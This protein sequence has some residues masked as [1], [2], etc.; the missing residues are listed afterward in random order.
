MKL[1][2]DSGDIEEI[3]SAYTWGG[4]DGVTSNPK[5][6]AKNCPGG[7]KEFLHELK[8]MGKKH[9]VII[10]LST[11]EQE[12]MLQE[13]REL[14]ELYP[15]IIIK[16]YMTEHDLE[17]MQD[18]K[19]AGIR[20]HVSLIYSLNQAFL[21][22][23]AGADVISPFVGRSDDFGGDGIGLLEDVIHMVERYSFSSSVM[24]ASLR[25]PFH[26][27]EAIRLGSD[28]ITLPYSILL[29][30]FR[31]PATNEGIADFKSYSVNGA[32]K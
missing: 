32:G 17:L 30:M 23:K 24:A 11:H 8:K 15:E 12:E 6:I 13:A 2:L 28:I 19:A 20:V 16:L 26:V 29:K 3:K 4:L 21:A 31:H 7:N 9:P 18:L 25:T 22:A 1:F 10:T 14:A 5:L 27:S